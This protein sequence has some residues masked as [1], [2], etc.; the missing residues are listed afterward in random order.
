M[1]V[2]LIEDMVTK[3]AGE[4]SIIPGYLVKTEIL[5]WVLVS[6]SSLTDLTEFSKT[7]WELRDNFLCQW[8]IKL[9]SENDA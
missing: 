3:T 4:N 2:L 9:K 5:N 7:D 6:W 8:Y 1:A